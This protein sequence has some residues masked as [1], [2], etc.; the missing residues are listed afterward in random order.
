M[1]DPS[2]AHILARLQMHYEAH[3][4]LPLRATDAVRPAQAT[5]AAVLT[6]EQLRRVSDAV[7]GEWR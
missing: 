5:R 3:T 4:P 7:I 1:T 6:L 2:A